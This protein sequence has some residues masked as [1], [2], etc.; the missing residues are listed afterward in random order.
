MHVDLIVP[1][2]NEVGNLR[3]LVDRTTAALRSEADDRTFGILLVVSDRS[4]DRTVE[5]ASEL[6]REVPEVSMLLKPRTS[7]SGTHSRTVSITP[8]ATC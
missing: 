4:S 2:Y 5:L 6:E 7:A 1:A 8:M 3:R